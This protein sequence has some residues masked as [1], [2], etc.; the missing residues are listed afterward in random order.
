MFELNTT[1]LTGK[2]LISSPFMEDEHFNKTVVYICSH[3]KDGAIGFIINKKL[4]NI[5][6]DDLAAQ[7]PIE[8]YAGSCPVAL[9]NGGPSEKIRGFVLHSTD[10]IKSDTVIIDR[11]IAVSSSIDIITDI[12]FGTGPKDNLIALGYAGWGPGQLEKEIMNNS[13]I[14]TTPETELV[15]RTKDEEKWEA[16]LHK[17][18]ISVDQLSFYSGRA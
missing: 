13:W 6:F 4:E 14:I 2:C 7:L 5:S 8:H 9:H 18:G 12:A 3:T 15:F 11:Q 16:A 1:N 10:Y 17:T